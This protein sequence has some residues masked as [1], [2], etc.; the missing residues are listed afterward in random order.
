M[1]IWGTLTIVGIGSLGCQ[2]GAFIRFVRSALV[3]ARTR[4]HGY[5]AM[6]REEN[7]FIIGANGRIDDA[8]LL[9]PPPHSSFTRRD[10]LRTQ[11]SWTPLSLRSESNHRLQWKPK[12]IQE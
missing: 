1:L 8:R 5:R 10:S 2:L 11:P 12:V 7:T 4:F 6:G 3:E 9:R